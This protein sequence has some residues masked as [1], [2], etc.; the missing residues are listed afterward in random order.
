MILILPTIFFCLIMSKRRVH[1]S[2]NRDFCEMQIIS[3]N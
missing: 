2:D 1:V 3:V